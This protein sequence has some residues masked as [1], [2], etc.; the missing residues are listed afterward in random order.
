MGAIRVCLK[1]VCGL[2]VHQAE[3]VACLSIQDARG[4]LKRVTRRFRTVYSELL[5]LRDWLV[6]EGCEAL[7]MEARRP[8]ENGHSLTIPTLE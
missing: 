8:R 7:G 5:Q 2:D 6:S 1:V 4:R 3:V